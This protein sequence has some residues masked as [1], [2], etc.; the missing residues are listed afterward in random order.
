MPKTP[1]WIAITKWQLQLFCGKIEITWRKGL[2]ELVRF[3]SV[4]YT[5]GV[6]ILLTSHFEFHH[7]FA[8]LNLDGPG[9]LPTCSEQEILDLSNLLGLQEWWGEEEKEKDNESE[10]QHSTNEYKKEE[11]QKQ[12]DDRRKEG[13][14]VYVCFWLMLTMATAREWSRRR[15]AR[16][17]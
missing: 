14:M 4:E 12:M 8:S 9:I 2:L 3:L 16:K 5:E 10:R 1:V 11:K 13:E 7:V 6:E 15:C 17:P